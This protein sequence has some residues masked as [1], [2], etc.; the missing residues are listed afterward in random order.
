MHRLPAFD[1]I[2]G[3]PLYVSEVRS[4][5]SG[6]AMKGRFAIPRFARL[7][8]DQ[9]KFLETFLRCRGVLSSVEKEMGLSYPTVRNRL[10]QL[11]TA[12]ELPAGPV[13]D[14]NGAG[15]ED[16][17]RILDQLERGEISVEEAKVKIRGGSQ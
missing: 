8:E 1:P 14:A 16:Q 3:H 6:I 12:L 11:L 5:E 13:A 9:S 2:T 15:I 4:D 17:R 7:T 10:D